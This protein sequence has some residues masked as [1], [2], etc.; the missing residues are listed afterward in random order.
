MDKIQIVFITYVGS[1]KLSVKR[2][3]QVVCFELIKSNFYDKTAVEK[4]V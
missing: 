2:I 3:K 1:G 4:N